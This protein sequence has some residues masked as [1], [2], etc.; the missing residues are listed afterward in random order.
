MIARSVFSR[1]VPRSLGQHALAGGTARQGTRRTSHGAP[2]VFVQRLGQAVQIVLRQIG[3][4]ALF[5]IDGA[6][7]HA[8][9]HP[10]AL[11]PQHPLLL[12]PFGH[13]PGRHLA[14]RAVGQRPVGPV[15]VRQGK[16]AAQLDRVHAE[17][18]EHVVVDNGQLLEGV[19]DANRPRRQAE[20]ATEL[21]IGHGRNARRAMSAEI[22]GYFVGR[23]MA[24]CRQN[25]FSRCHGLV[26]RASNRKSGTPF[27]EGSRKIGLSA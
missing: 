8:G 22:D 3:P 11:G 6:V 4:V 15:L 10:A 27:G 19:V 12:L 14:G 18:F 20:L 2:H 9:Q 7:G 26:P 5:E 17:S 13:G 23:S 25:P 1:S 16:P 21:R 24:E